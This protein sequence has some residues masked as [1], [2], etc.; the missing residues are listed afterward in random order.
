[1]SK[2]DGYSNSEIAEE[3]GISVKTVENQMTK[4]YRQLRDAL[5]P[6]VGRKV[7]FLPFL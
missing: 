6:V 5:A 2:R 7:F 1:M 3:L 4:A